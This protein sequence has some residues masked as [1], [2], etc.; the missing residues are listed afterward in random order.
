MLK[1]INLLLLALLIV[2]NINAQTQLEKWY[3]SGKEI[4]MTSS[5]AAIAATYGSSMINDNGPQNAMY[6]ENGDLQF[7]VNGSRIFDKFDVIQGSISSS[8][9]NIGYERAEFT[10]VPYLDNNSCRNKYYLFYADSYTANGNKTIGLFGKSIEVNK[11][12]SALTIQNLNSG[13][14]LTSI[15]DPAANFSGIHAL[16]S[17]AVSN[18]KNGK[19]YLY[20]V[21]GFNASGVTYTNYTGKVSKVE[22]S[23][24]TISNPSGLSAATNLSLPSSVKCF[25]AGEADLSDDGTKLVWGCSRISTGNYAEFYILNLNGNGDYSS[26]STFSSTVQNAGLALR[27]VEF[28][29][30]AKKLF[31]TTGGTTSSTGGVYV[32]NLVNNTDA[33]VAS[34]VTFSGSQIERGTNG[35]MY[36]AKVGTIAGIDPTT[37]TFSGPSLAVS[38]PKYPNG[39]VLPDQID[40]CNYD[41]FLFPTTS[42]DQTV[43]TASGNATWTQT[44]NPIKTNGQPIRIQNTLR[45]TGG[46]GTNITLNGMTFEFGENAK[47][48]LDPGV[49]VTLYNSTLKAFD[50]AMMWDGIEV[51][52]NATL[53]SNSTPTAYNP[54]GTFILDAHAGISTS[55]DT[56]KPHSIK[57]DIQMTQFDRNHQHI[58]LINGP[59]GTN[60]SIKNNR[61]FHSEPLRD[62]SGTYGVNDP[63]SS[64]FYGRSS[65]EVLNYLSPITAETII[66]NNLFHRGFRGINVYRSALKAGDNTFQNMSYIAGIGIYVNSGNSKNTIWVDGNS[67]NN[68]YRAFYEIYDAHVTFVNN[69]VYNTLSTAVY[70]INNKDCRISV[71]GNVMRGCKEN[72]ILLSSNAGT[73]NNNK[74]EINVSNNNIGLQKQST[75][76]TISEASRSKSLSYSKMLVNHNVINDVAFGIKIYNVIGFQDKQAKVSSVGNSDVSFNN[77]T[78]YATKTTNRMASDY[79]MGIFLSACKGLAVLG[80]TINTS[81]NGSWRNCGIES[82]N[83]TSTLIKDNVIKAGRGVSAIENAWDNNYVCNIFNQNVN[84]ISLGDHK[85]RAAGDVHGVF[86]K[87]SRD[88]IFSGSTDKDIEL[89][90]WH[91]DPTN[92]ANIVTNINNNKWIFLPTPSLMYYPD[93][94]PIFSN[95]PG[96]PHINYLRANQGGEMPLCNVEGGSV[97]P[98]FWGPPNA[99]LANDELFF[100]QWQYEYEKELKAAGQGQINNQFISQLIDVEQFISEQDYAQANQVLISMQAQSAYEQ[101]LKSVF[102]ILVDVMINDH[103]ALSTQEISTLSTIASGTTYDNGTAVLEARNFLWTEAGLEFNDQADHTSPICFNVNYDPCY[104]QLPVVNIVLI[105]NQYNSYPNI[106]ITIDATGRANLSG[107]EINNLD[108]NLM[109]SFSIDLPHSP[110]PFLTIEDWQ[111][112]DINITDLCEI[113]NLEG[114]ANGIS[115]NKK[116]SVNIYPNPSNENFIIAINELVADRIEVTDMV[117]RILF[118]SPISVG[119]KLIPINSSNWTSGTYILKIY[120][121]DEVVKSHKLIKM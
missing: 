19:R 73:A 108:P 64:Q 107:F 90:L 92:P 91:I 7:Y 109:Y 77:I 24:P 78:F 16:S 60:I 113:E 15:F 65:I 74:S 58:V 13:A 44:S 87:E 94:N 98:S 14:A 121:H 34:S 48:I 63:S 106:P 17:I 35:I 62:Q 3:I 21:A 99:D 53:Y 120:N 114:K 25:S 116:E 80:D 50:C 11:A 39:F 26:F 69:T 70:I 29:T 47:M 43:F 38:P 67:F 79:N 83:T 71:L 6:D 88:N 104:D 52:D 96:Y 40:G 112:M 18:I 111:N 86:K 37:N 36:V 56:N 89:Y 72:A 93:P 8:S 4:D 41:N 30:D 95:P 32:R 117:G 2:S 54:V 57:L 10:I 75:G 105:D 22:I 20:W 9:I 101:N 51:S 5:P 49:K 66:N 23:T 27:G 55:K 1:K 97:P 100:W 45:F 82:N 119:E 85:L 12:T 118:S 61:F 33:Y 68:T 46:A 76:I 115:N 28:T 103:R 110:L 102:D 81:M 84:G 42:F 59:G 31:Y